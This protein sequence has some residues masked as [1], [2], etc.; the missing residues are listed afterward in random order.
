MVRRPTPRPATVS[1]GLG[2]RGGT[3]PTP[4][5]RTVL[6][7]VDLIPRGKVLTYGDVAELTGRGTGRTVGTVMSR[8]GRQVPWWRVVQAS[9]RPAEPHVQE[10]LDRLRREGC[11]VVG[12]VVDLDRAR[13]DGSSR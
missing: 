9:G 11:P 4:Y 10:A 6:D 1:A 7:A 12:E 13:W 2:V 8:H 3:T 5:A